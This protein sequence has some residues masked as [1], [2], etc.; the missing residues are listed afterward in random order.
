MNLHK[1]KQLDLDFNSPTAAKEWKYWL[2]TINNCIAECGNGALDKYR[3]IINHN[4]FDYV[5]DGV[6]FDS[7]VVLA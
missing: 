1:P 2:R 5:E 7:V 3:T 6:D 4:V